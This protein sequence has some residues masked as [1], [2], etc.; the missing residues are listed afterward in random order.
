MPLVGSEANGFSQTLDGVEE[1]RFQEVRFALSILGLG[2]LVHRTRLF[3]IRRNLD[4]G[5]SRRWTRR[6]PEP[7]YLAARRFRAKRAVVAAAGQW[8]GEFLVRL[9]DFQEKLF[10]LPMHV[11]KERGMMSIGMVLLAMA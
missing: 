4:A 9:L 8:I 10:Q 3:S 1:T 6:W 5:R 11:V 2:H 7:G